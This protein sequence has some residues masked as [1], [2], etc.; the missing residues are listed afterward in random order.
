MCLIRVGQGQGRSR[1]ILAGRRHG[2][3]LVRIAVVVVLLLSAG[4]RQR[5]KVGR[6]GLGC[7]K[8]NL[9]GLLSQGFCDRNGKT[10]EVQ[11]FTF[12]ITR[13][14]TDTGQF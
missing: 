11:E 6:Q 3:G 10:Q 4:K 2:R 9:V 8:N 5:P 14:M 13:S 12:Q 1:P 7:G